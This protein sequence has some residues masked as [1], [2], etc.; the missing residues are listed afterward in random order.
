MS[1][2]TG[3]NWL[4]FLAGASLGTAIGIVCAPAAGAET[5]R[6]LSS[7]AME[8]RQNLRVNSREMFERGREL[9]D[10]GRRLADEAA[11]MFDEGR[12]LVEG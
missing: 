8:G 12:R 3:T 11:D 9:Y 7:K 1:A 6:Y 2:H 4:W 10:K 5:R